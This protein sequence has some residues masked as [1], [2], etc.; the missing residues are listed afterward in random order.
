MGWVVVGTA[1]FGAPRFPIF[2]WKNA[3]FSRILARNRGAPKTA[4]PTTTHLLKTLTSLNKEVRPF[5]LATIAFGVF[6]LVLLLAIVASGGPEGH[7]SL[8]I[9][10]F[11]AFGLIVPE[12]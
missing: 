1:V 11:G 8:V 5:F 2:L 6:P 7:F 10:A 12:Y 4:V 3:I 9:I